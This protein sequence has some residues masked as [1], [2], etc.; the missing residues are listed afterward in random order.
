MKRHFKLVV[1]MLLIFLAGGTPGPALGQFS[2]GMPNIS[3]SVCTI[4]TRPVTFG[5][6]DSFDPGPRDT[7]G[8]V[9]Y[10]CVRSLRDSLP[11]RIEMSRGRAS[12]FNRAMFKNTEQL[13]YNLYLDATRRTVWGNGSEGTEYYSE[14]NAPN[15]KPVVVPVY[16]R[17]YPLQDVDGGEYSDVIEVKILF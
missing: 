17:I 16:G 6:Y 5:E 12:S 4:D 8:A 3:L 11:I 13:N 9:I 10:V 15:K 14:S 7:Q 2:R 1:G